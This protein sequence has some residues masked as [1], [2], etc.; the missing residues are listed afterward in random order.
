MEWREFLAYII[1]CC[2]IQY[3]QLRGIGVLEFKVGCMGLYALRYYYRLEYAYQEYYHRHQIVVSNKLIFSMT[4][5]E[6]IPNHV[7]GQVHVDYEWWKQLMDYC[8]ELACLT[9]LGYRAMETITWRVS[10]EFTKFQITNA[11][12]G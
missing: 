7:V 12:L 8:H 10:Y 2:Y 9:N 6:T 5:M 3:H 1:V 4:R 11:H